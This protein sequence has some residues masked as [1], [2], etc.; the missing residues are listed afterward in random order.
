MCGIFALI[1]NTHDDELIRTA[2][3]KG[4]HRGPETSSIIKATVDS[5]I[6]FGFN[7]L[8]INSS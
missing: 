7:R 3:N 4:K 5:K 2:F 1:N 8:S 6:I